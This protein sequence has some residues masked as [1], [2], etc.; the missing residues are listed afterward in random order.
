MNEKIRDFVV[1]TV[2]ELT[3]IPEAEITADS[4]LIGENAVLD[5]R[6][7]VMVMLDAEDFLEAEYQA[8]FNWNS[9][10]ALSAARSQLRTVGTL[11]EL[12]TSTAEANH[13][14]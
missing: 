3:G 13:G 8:S 12:L 14:G 6:D 9:D 4:Q 10:S 1:R 7:L 11:T 2:S 5:S